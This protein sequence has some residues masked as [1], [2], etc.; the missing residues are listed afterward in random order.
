MI[1]NHQKE[2]GS[3]AEKPIPS[4]EKLQAKTAD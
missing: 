1:I 3:E 2:S 4:E